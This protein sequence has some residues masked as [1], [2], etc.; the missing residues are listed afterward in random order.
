LKDTDFADPD[1]TNVVEYFTQ[2]GCQDLIQSSSVA[3]DGSPFS[4]LNGIVAVRPPCREISLGYTQL[5]SN[6]VEGRFTFHLTVTGTNG[7]FWSGAYNC[8]LT[9]V[10]SLRYLDA[11][12]GIG[13]RN[14]TITNLGSKILAQFGSDIAIEG[15]SYEGPIGSGAMPIDITQNPLTVSLVAQKD[16]GATW[17]GAIVLSPATFYRVGQNH[18]VRW[19]RLY[20]GALTFTPNGTS[21]VLSLCYDTFNVPNTYYATNERDSDPPVPGPADG[22][23]RLTTLVMQQGSMLAAT[24]PLSSVDTDDAS[25]WRHSVVAG[26]AIDA[27]V[28]FDFGGD[29]KVNDQRRVYPNF[30]A[31][32]DPIIFGIGIQA[33]GSAMIR[34]YQIVRRIDNVCI[35]L[36]R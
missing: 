11:T 20:P 23:T 28:W 36:K 8:N 21:P 7:S 13:S 35:R 33:N 34:D 18:G 16:P 2:G 10:P 19:W 14:C 30:A 32:G 29:P 22:G 31:G 9:N 17:P 4:C 3:N 5:R 25:G 24:Y 27:M 1:G 6:V 12:F 26:V 15:A